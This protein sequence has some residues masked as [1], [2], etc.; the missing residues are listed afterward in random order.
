[1]AVQSLGTD[2]SMEYLIQKYAKTVYRLALART[3]QKSDAED[4]F[5]EVFLRYV[6]K[7]PRF[8]SEEHEKAWFLRVTVNCAN[9]LYLSAFRKNTAP[10]DEKMP[11]PEQDE[12]FLEEYLQQL[13]PICRTVI[14]LYYYEGLQTEE[15][16][17]LL[18]KSP[19][20]I[21]ATLTRARKALKISMEGDL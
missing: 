20:T 17:K 1:M 4:V 18:H 7:K 10:L 13:S 15:I 9:N 5:Q 21:R 14:H 19:S 3:G 8:Q 2:D 12:P 16:A 11:A 6:R